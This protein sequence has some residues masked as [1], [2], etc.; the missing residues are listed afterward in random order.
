V[1]RKDSRIPKL[2]SVADDNTITKLPDMS[3]TCSRKVSNDCCDCSWLSEPPLYICAECA[4]NESCSLT[5]VAECATCSRPSA[6]RP[7]SK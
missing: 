1:L 5:F 3:D 4:E 2:E 7:K 6:F